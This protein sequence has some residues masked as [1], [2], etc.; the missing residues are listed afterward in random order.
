MGRRATVGDNPERATLMIASVN[1]QVNLVADKL[2]KDGAA[3]DVSDEDGTTGLMYE[4][5]DDASM[6]LAGGANKDAK[7]ADES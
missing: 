1:G 2:L 7:L 3:V 6:V 4:V 5:Q